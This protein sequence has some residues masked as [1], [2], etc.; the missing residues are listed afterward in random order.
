M[1]GITTLMVIHY[2]AVILDTVLPEVPD[3]ELGPDD[4]RGP[5]DHHEPDAHHPS[6]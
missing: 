3:R 1:T 5:E 6:S 2:I 4:H